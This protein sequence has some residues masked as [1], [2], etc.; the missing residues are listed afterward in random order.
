MIEEPPPLTVLAIVTSRQTDWLQGGQV[1]S[2]EMR[3]RFAFARQRVERSRRGVHVAGVQLLL[4]RV[5]APS[6]LHSQR[7]AYPIIIGPIYIRWGVPTSRSL[8][9]V[10]AT[11]RKPW[12]TSSIFSIAS[13]TIWCAPSVDCVESG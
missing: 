13:T 7:I 2:E 11:C 8:E 6:S 1:T 9:S 4:T 3:W 12:M 5:A 10:S